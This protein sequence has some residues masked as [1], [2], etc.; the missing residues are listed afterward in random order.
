MRLPLQ[1]RTRSWGEQVKRNT[2][3]VLTLQSHLPARIG[4][5]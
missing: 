3:F 2:P 4:L 5:R 1:R